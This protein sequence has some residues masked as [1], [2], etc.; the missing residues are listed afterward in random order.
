M[1]YHLSLT[2]EQHHVFVMFYSEHLLSAPSGHSIKPCQGCVRAH[3][4]KQ[5]EIVGEQDIRHCGTR[6]T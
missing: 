4:S 3:F 6:V 1:T 5:P 2:L